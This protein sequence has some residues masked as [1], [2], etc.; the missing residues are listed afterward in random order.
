M[1]EIIETIHTSRVCGKRNACILKLK[2]KD[3]GSLLSEK[4]N[5]KPGIIQICEIEN[6]KFSH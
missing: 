6:P 1:K 4:K 2:P 5:C 3:A